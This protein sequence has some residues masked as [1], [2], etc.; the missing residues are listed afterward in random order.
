V[1]DLLPEV[2]QPVKRPE[3]WNRLPRC[4]WCGRKT[5]DG[6]GKKYLCPCGFKMD[7]PR[8]NK[9]RSLRLYVSSMYLKDE[10]NLSCID[11]GNGLRLKLEDRRV[12]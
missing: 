3:D 12:K 5:I 4:P 2:I 8:C 7:K 1:R 11:C 9:C 10:F 6:S